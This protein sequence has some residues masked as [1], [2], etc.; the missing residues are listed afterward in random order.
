VAGFKEFSIKAAK[1]LDTY[2]VKS[3]P[4]DGVQAH[5]YRKPKR[6]GGFEKGVDKSQNWVDRFLCSA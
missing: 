4:F 2:V 1:I 3:F 6:F 5:F